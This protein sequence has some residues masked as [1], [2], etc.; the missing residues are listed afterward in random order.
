M[1]PGYPFSYF[2]WNLCRRFF[3]LLTWSIRSAGFSRSVSSSGK[4]GLSRLYMDVLLKYRIVALRRAIL[5]R[6]ALI[7]SAPVVFIGTLRRYYPRESIVQPSVTSAFS[8]CLRSSRLFF[9]A[10]A[11][12]N[13][14]LSVPNVSVTSAERC[15]WVS[16][17][18]STNLTASMIAASWGL[19]SNGFSPTRDILLVNCIYRTLTSEH[20][21]AFFFPNCASL[22]WADG[23]TAE[24]TSHILL[25][26]RQMFWSIVL[27]RWVEG[28]SRC[29]PAEYG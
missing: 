10:L 7:G 2:T 23:S 24:E 3:S 29:N 11:R 25:M 19:S 27:L 20:H 8:S 15:M 18:L 17:F 6:D 4:Y 1:Y 16:A 13:V 26:G 22:R 14:I 21:F 12:L 5:E 28:P 9:L